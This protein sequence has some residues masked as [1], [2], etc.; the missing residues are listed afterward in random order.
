MKSNALPVSLLKVTPTAGHP[1]FSFF[2]AVR[3][4]P[5]KN[6][7]RYEGALPDAIRYNIPLSMSKL[8]FVR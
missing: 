8:M 1:S 4:P 5:A 7:G 6:L 2:K 3:L